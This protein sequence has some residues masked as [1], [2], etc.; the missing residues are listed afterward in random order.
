[1]N[2][3]KKSN[4][5][6]GY[7]LRN[8]IINAVARMMP[9]MAELVT[10]TVSPLACSTSLLLLAAKSAAIHRIGRAQITRSRVVRRSRRSG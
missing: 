9:P 1:M 6:L 10:E 3:R 7:R 8:R 5:H 2:S 4:H